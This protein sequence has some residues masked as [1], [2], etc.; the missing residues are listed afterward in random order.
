MFNVCPTRFAGSPKSSLKTTTPFSGCYGAATARRQ[1]PT[2]NS[3]DG[4]A[5]FFDSESVS[6]KGSLKTNIPHFQAVY[7]AATT[8]RQNPTANS[9]DDGTMFFDGESASP[10][11]SLKTEKHKHRAALFAHFQAAY[12]QAKP[13]A[14]FSQQGTA[15]SPTQRRK[16]GSLKTPNRF[17]A[18]P[19]KTV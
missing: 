10:K 17:Q 13:P 19:Q 2:D 6:P 4:W 11:G 8:R 9:A 3:A 16:K 12:S 14:Y 1:N 5:T 15:T 18:A 7:G